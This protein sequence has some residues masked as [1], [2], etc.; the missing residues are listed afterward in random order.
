MSTPPRYRTKV[1]AILK[2]TGSDSDATPAVA[3]LR[4]VIDYTI[5]GSSPGTITADVVV[6]TNS[7]IGGEG[8]VL[9]DL[10][11][12]TWFVPTIFR[13]RV[14]ERDINPAGPD[15]VILDRRYDFATPENWADGTEHT[16]TQTVQFYTVILKYR[17]EKL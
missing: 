12:T 11:R 15:L 14:V 1:T 4:T 16:V 8:L 7:P 6:P 9:A 5:L 17:V 13:I 3:E 2:R 10:V